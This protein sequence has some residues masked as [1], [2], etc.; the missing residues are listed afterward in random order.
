MTRRTRKR[1]ARKRAKPV[2]L[3]RRSI[4]PGRDV[5]LGGGLYARMLFGSAQY[6]VALTLRMR[7]AG[8]LTVLSAGWRDTPREAAECAEQAMLRLASALRQVGMS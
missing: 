8:D 7:G 6:Q 1:Q 4:A 5:A 3:C 2:E